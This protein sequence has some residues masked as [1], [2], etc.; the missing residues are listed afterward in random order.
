MRG[1]I[2]TLHKENTMKIVILNENEFNELS[3]THD[4]VALSESETTTLCSL[5]GACA[6]IDRADIDSIKTAMNVALLE[7]MND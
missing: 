3:Q 1:F 4:L 5:V 2:F 6:D 7:D